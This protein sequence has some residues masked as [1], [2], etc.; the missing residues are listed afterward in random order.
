[1]FKIG[2]TVYHITSCNKGIVIDILKYYRINEIKYL[3]SF[4]FNEAAWCLADELTDEK[5]II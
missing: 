4:G 2:Q 3:V 5:P 1:M